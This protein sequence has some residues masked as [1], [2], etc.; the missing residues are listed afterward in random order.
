MVSALIREENEQYSLN[1]I[2]QDGLWKK[3]IGDLFEEFLLF[4]L[5]ELHGHIDFN[6]KPAFLDKELF[7]EVG[8]EQKGRRFADRL[9][10]VYLKNGE[11][12]W[13]LIHIE[14]Q[15]RNEAEF[16]KRI[17]QYFYRIFDRCDKKVVALA[18]HTSLNTPEIKKPI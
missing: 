9:A 16:P 5:P 10:K 3:V 12:R 17:F 6:E 14:A 18:V 8:D 15:N 4:F 11:E 13:I 1:K 2:D 7:Q